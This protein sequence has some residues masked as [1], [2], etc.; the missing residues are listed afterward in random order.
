MSIHYLQTGVVMGRRWYGSLRM[1]HYHAHLSSR[2]PLLYA[3]IVVGVA[4]CRW[5]TICHQLG[6]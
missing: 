4:L 3:A 2:Q 5:G 1:R 6:P